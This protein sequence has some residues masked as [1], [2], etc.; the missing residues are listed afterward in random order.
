MKL[1]AKDIIKLLL[2]KENMTQRELASLITSET[3]K[4]LTQDGLSR[5][6]N[7]DTIT[8]REFSSIVDILGYSINIEHK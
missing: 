3:G 6:L 1:T 2:S 7:R 5:N 8:Y 4:K